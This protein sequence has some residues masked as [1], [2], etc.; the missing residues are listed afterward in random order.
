VDPEFSSVS[1]WLVLAFAP[2]V[3]AA[4]TAFTKV[5]VVLSAL[6]VGLGAERLLPWSAV[7]ALSVVVTVVIMTP[8]GLAMFGAFEAGGGASSLAGADWGAWAGLLDPLLGFLRRHA[9]PAEVEFF[10]GLQGL[11]AGHPLAVVPAFLVTELYEAFA[12]AVLILIPLVAVD[13]LLAQLF[14]LTGLGGQPALLVS[15]PC[16]LLLFLAVDGWDLILG[17]LVEGYQL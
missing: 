9:S 2:L 12:M 7:F 17:G 15:L 3:L 13:V 14:V 1:L 8:V 16:K 6:R 4:C 5:S 11:G 10:A